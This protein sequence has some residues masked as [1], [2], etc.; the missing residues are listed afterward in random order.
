MSTRPKKKQRP[1]V[2]DTY[3]LNP[4]A[5]FLI[6]AQNM[7]STITAEDRS[8]MQNARQQHLQGI[9]NQEPSLHVV[10]PAGNNLPNAR[11]G[12][13]FNH[14]VGAVDAAFSPPEEMLPLRPEEF[15]GANRLL[16]AATLL[17]NNPS[18]AETATQQTN[19]TNDTDATVIVVN[20]DATTA[21]DTTTA[22]IQQARPRQRR[23]GRLSTNIRQSRQQSI[24]NNTIPIDAD[25]RRELLNL[26]KAK[27]NRRSEAV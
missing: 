27:N 24:R 6:Q 7:E 18:I 25:T 2:E 4:R 17:V 22:V 11:Q 8:A 16:E 9:G 14:L 3:T 21:A 23:E 1:L 15:D 5:E 13:F 20:D 12:G 26:N 19:P 10:I